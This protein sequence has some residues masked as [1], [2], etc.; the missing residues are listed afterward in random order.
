MSRSG[1][2][3]CINLVDV[4]GRVAVMPRERGVVKMK[5]L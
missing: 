1:F 4:L 3:I 2:G 5:G